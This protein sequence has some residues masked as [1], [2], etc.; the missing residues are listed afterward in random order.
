[1]LRRHVRLLATTLVAAF[2]AAGPLAAAAA[3]QIHC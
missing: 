2:L 3:A 1:M